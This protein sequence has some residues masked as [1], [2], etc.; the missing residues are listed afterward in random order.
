LTKFGRHILFAVGQL[1]V[2][3]IE[4]YVLRM[5]R[6]CHAAGGKVSVWAVKPQHDV[7]LVRMLREVADV[8]FLFPPAMIYPLWISSPPLPADV[9]LVFTTGRASLLFAA[10]ACA[11][12][13]RPIRLVAGV[14]SQ[15]EYCTDDDNPKTR[16]AAAIIQQLG[17]A[18]MVFC[19]E[20]CRRDHLPLLGIAYAQS[21]VSPL[22][23]ELPIPKQ[24][25]T[26]ALSQRFDI[27]SVSR[28]VKFKTSN[29]QMPSVLKSLFDEGLDVHWTLYG[30]GPQ[31]REIQAAIDAAGMQLRATL[32]GPL[33]YSQ[34][35]NAI[36]KADLYIG[37]GTTM[38]EASALGVPSLVALDENT[39]PTSPGFFADRVG[40]YTSELSS[41][42]RLRPIFDIILETIKLSKMKIELLQERS[43]LRASEYDT[44]RAPYEFGKIIDFAKAISVKLPPNFQFGHTTGALL[45]LARHAL[46]G[47][48]P[49]TSGETPSNRR[50]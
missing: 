11:R 4:T 50:S 19:T 28:L 48:M 15:W 35:H 8:T 30:E 14:F 49:S 41:N 3:G 7:E 2:G 36:A 16:L 46:T 12:E 10:Y 39:M 31:R 32:A 26:R 1:T 34:I 40:H 25:P 6:A 38:I 43:R 17:P 42:E 18:N 5:A 21:L 33:P 22:L 44:K 23:I 47:I 20:G 45:D 29:L 13:A 27:V 24:R 37:G 9:D